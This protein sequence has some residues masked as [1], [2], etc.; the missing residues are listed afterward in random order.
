MRIKIVAPWVVLL[1]CATLLSGCSGDGD[2]GADPIAGADFEDLGLEAT[3]TTGIIRGI[4]VDEA[5]RPLAGADVGTTLPDGGS[6]NTTSAA[7]GAFG[8]DGLPGGTYFLTIRKPGYLAQQANTD[9]VVGVAEPAIVKVLLTSDPTSLPYVSVLQFDAFI[10]CSVT[11]PSVSVALCDVVEPVKEA[12]NNRFLVNYEADKPP[13]WIQSEAIWESTQPLG[14]DLSLSFTDFSSGPQLVVNSTDGPSPIHITVNETTAR[15][16]NYGINN[17]LTL[18]LFSTTVEGTDVVPEEMAQDAYASSVYGPL[19]S[20]GAP[21]TYQGVADQ[22]NEADPT[23]LEIVGNPFG[24]PDCI[25]YPV[26]FNACYRFGGAGVVFEQR[27]TVYTHI[28][29]G[30]TPPPGWTFSATGETPQPP[31]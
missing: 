14:N 1:S 20:T 17:T 23:G 30:F 25:K 9:V 18:R 4:V 15:H 11:S 10:G 19:N 2:Q 3:P 16:F 12:T 31:A 6:R 22:A 29:Y 8:F 28:F 26:L 27:V 21:S 7:D 5:I 24:D 13:Q